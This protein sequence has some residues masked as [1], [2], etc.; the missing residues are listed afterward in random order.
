MALVSCCTSCP[1]VQTTDIP[2]SEGPAGTDGADGV[3]AFT[4]TTADFIVP[5]LSGSVT[6]SGANFSWAQIGQP[7]F[8]QGAGMFEVTAKA[9]NNLS[10]TVTYLDYDSNTE[11][12]TTISAG[13]GVSP[14]SFQPSSTLLPAV[15]DYHTAGSQA[16]TDSALQ[17]LSSEVTLAAKSY[18]ILA[19]VRLDFN[20]TT[21]LA[22]R[23]VTLKLR[24]TTNGP[25]DLSNTTV[26]AG[27]G[28]VTDASG[29]FEI[30][31]LPPVVYAAAAGDT[32]QMFGIISSVPYVGDVLAVEV[33][34]VA[35]PLF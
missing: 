23:T 11:T 24:E 9:S 28:I 20:G 19:R 12:G 16:L 7:V 34:I 8:V 1:E 14:G 15:T 22:N 2:G 27:T 17:L 3:D 10:I 33:S 4:V 26:G 5:A 29:T 21:T 32:V 6:I 25:A 35:L 13:A 31:D 30:L 18:L